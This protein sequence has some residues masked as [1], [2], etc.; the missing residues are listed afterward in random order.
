MRSK[1]W[2]WTKHLEFYVEFKKYAQGAG[3]GGMMKRVMIYVLLMGCITVM[4][5][6]ASTD[7]KKDDKPAN[8]STLSDS[9]I[10]IQA[11][12][13][14][15]RVC[16]NKI[17][18]TEYKIAKLTMQSTLETSQEIAELEKEKDGYE[19]EYNYLLRELRYLKRKSSQ[20]Q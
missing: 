17:R 6:C 15:L 2:I 12:E 14:R 4:S 19:A 9:E 18:K 8:G 7:M 13:D 1:L 5:G 3:E 20:D 11:L 16:A 10:Q